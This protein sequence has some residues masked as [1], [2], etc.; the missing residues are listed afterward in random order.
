[1]L[2]TSRPVQFPTALSCFTGWFFLPCV[3]C[4]T[5]WGV[6]R[7]AVCHLSALAYCA[8]RGSVVTSCWQDR[9][10]ELSPGAYS[11]KTLFTKRFALHW[12]KITI[13]LVIINQDGYISLLPM[14]H[15]YY[16]FQLLHWTLSHFTAK[17]FPPASICY[18]ES[19]KKN[20]LS[21]YSDYCH[22]RFIFFCWRWSY[23]MKQN[24][25]KKI[26]VNA[27]FKKN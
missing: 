2:R 15:T 27:P 12:C 6:S 14:R 23:K 19:Q 8:V 13:L 24:K 26:K 17:W 11:L 1:M 20:E 18:S 7:P 22:H 4:L 9:V 3:R 5:N 10:Q 21:K 25:N 16:R